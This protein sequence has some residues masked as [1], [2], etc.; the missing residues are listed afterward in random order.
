MSSFE[1]YT[2]ADKPAKLKYRKADIEKSRNYLTIWLLCREINNV[3]PTVSV[4]FQ[5]HLYSEFFIKMSLV[6]ES[7][8]F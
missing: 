5:V 6:F 4:L 8:Y 7:E 3:R 1:N 2:P